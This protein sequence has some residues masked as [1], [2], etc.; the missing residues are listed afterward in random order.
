MS[1]SPHPFY[2]IGLIILSQCAF[3]LMD[4]VIKVLSQSLPTETILLFRNIIPLILLLPIVA[5]RRIIM[6][7]LPRLPLHLI[8]SL[9]GLAAMYSLFFA[10]SVLPLAEVSVLRTTT[11]LFIPVLAF[12]WLRES[13]TPGLIF[14]LILGF[15]GVL[16]VLKPGIATFSIYA[17]FPL[18]SG[19]MTAFAMV[20]IKRMSGIASS[21]EIVF[22]FALIGTLLSSGLCLIS[23]WRLDGGLNL[24]SGQLWLWVA[25]LGGLA[26]IGQLLLTQAHH[27]A[28]ASTLSPFYYLTVVFG[29]LLGH[30]VWGERLGWLGWLGAICITIAGIH[31]SRAGQWPWMRI[32]R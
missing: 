1:P 22:Y 31:I 13:R 32:K 16:L 11:P 4:G 25:A 19:L 27:F 12:F 7:S 15:I 10:L 14:A 18:I 9:T 2:G 6:A 3:S 21:L 28:L 29:A 5:R 24:P 30:F 8:R 23:Y 20:S 26:T 17:I